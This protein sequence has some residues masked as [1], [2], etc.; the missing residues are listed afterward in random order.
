MRVRDILRSERD[1]QRIDLLGL[2]SSALSLSVEKVITQGE[3]ELHAEEEERLQMLL[4]ERRRGRPVAYISGKKEFFSQDFTVDHRV[5]IP[6][7]ETETLVEEALRIMPRLP[8]RPWRV[9]DVGTGS[10]AVGITLARLTGAFATCLD[11][12]PDALE[13]AK[14]NTRRLAVEHLVDLVCSDLLSALGKGA[15][16]DLIVAN[17]P[18]IAVHEWMT[19]MPDVRLF[20]PKLALLGGGDGLDVYRRLIAGVRAHLSEEGHLLCEIGGPKQAQ[21]MSGLLGE[22]G[23]FVQTKNDLAGRER[24]VVGSCRSL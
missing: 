6:R 20:E 3:H 17:L 14:I 23:L 13:V 21:A 12:S 1:L 9:L 4:E 7:P 24:V 11:I 22:I 8:T 15:Q 10:G 2:L 18:Y 19:L 16:F 5:L